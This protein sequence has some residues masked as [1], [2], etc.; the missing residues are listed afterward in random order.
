MRFL[1]CNS[2]NFFNADPVQWKSGMR[3]QAIPR[4]LA[5]PF[6]VNGAVAHKQMSNSRYSK[7]LLW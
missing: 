1:L 4:A 2:M 7:Q 3:K 6:L 5:W